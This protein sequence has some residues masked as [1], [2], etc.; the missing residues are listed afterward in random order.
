MREEPGLQEEPGLREEDEV[1]EEQE[2]SGP[3]EEEER[4]HSALP[5]PGWEPLRP[6]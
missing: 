6:Q 2:E 3:C 1:E 4:L 5:P